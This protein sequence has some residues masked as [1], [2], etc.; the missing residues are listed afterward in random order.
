MPLFFFHWFIQK[1]ALPH[2]KV[3][4]LVQPSNDNGAELLSVMVPE[5]LSLKK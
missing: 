5:L 3:T 1:R 4:F 2:I